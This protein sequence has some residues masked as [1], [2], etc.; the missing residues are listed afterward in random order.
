MS[1]Q[2]RPWLVDEPRLLPASV[3]EFV[4]PGHLAHFIR[5]L[6]RE[7]L[8][9]SAITETYTEERGYPPYDPLGDDDGAPCAVWLQPWGL[10]VAQAGE[11][12]CVNGWISMAR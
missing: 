9:L 6:V 8:D 7:A 12:L 1:K 11:G 2:F 4:P 10:F 3:T 5:N